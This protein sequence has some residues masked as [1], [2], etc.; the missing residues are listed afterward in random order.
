MHRHHFLDYIVIMTNRNSPL[1]FQN[2]KE[3]KV[4]Y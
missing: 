4:F 1:T 2:L 3:L